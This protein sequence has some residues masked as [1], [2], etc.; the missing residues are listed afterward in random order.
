MQCTRAGKVDGTIGRTQAQ[1]GAQLQQ[2][3]STGMKKKR[4]PVTGQSVEGM[5]RKKESFEQRRRNDKARHCCRAL[6]SRR[7]LRLDRSEPRKV[8]TIFKTT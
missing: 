7:S 2:Q 3:L 8:Q 5:L 4:R 6:V 1:V